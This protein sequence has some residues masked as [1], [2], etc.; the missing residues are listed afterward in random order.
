MKTIIVTPS[1]N[2]PTHPLAMTVGGTVNPRMSRLFAD[3]VAADICLALA[4]REVTLATVTAPNVWSI[5]H[6]SVTGALRLDLQCVDGARRFLLPFGAPDLPDG[7][8]WRATY[9]DNR[10]DI[11]CGGGAL[12]ACFDEAWAVVCRTIETLRPER[13]ALSA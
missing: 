12:L 6:Q 11:E 10:F 1:Q 4:K 9:C 13:L 7:Q 5:E 3:A 8:P 2:R